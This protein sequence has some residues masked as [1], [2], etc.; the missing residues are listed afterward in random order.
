[1]N[2]FFSFALSPEQGTHALP[3]FSLVGTSL[4]AQSGAEDDVCN[5]VGGGGG[6][7]RGRCSTTDRQFRSIDGSCNN[8][9]TAHWGKSNIALQRLLD[10]KYEDG[11]A[12]NCIWATT[13]SAQGQTIPPQV[14]PFLAARCRRNSGR[15]FPPQEPSARH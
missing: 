9:G 4:E 10:P 1:M 11:N 13:T 12:R 3:V 6:E 5:S 8:L 7:G 15:L 2:S 14:C